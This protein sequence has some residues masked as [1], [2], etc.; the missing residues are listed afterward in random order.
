MNVLGRQAGA[1]V[2]QAE[3]DRLEIARLDSFKELAVGLDMVVDRDEEG[4]DSRGTVLWAQARVLLLC[5][6]APPIAAATHRR[7]RRGR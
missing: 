3:R 4:Q 2:A 5:L 1:H 6:I 7:G